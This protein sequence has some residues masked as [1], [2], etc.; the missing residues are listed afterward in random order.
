MQVF[1]ELTSI[2]GVDYLII[3]SYEDI[4]NIYA[5]LDRKASNISRRIITGIKKLQFWLKHLQ[6]RWHHEIGNSFNCSSID[7]N[8]FNNFKYHPFN[9][10]SSRIDPRPILPSSVPRK[11]IDSF[12][13]AHEESTIIKFETSSA[14]FNGDY[15]S[16]FSFIRGMSIK[17]LF[18]QCFRRTGKETKNNSNK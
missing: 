17:V 6:Q 8:Q 2:Y 13:S 7:E 5:Q 9:N 1:Q 15:S 12:L 14:S 4:C 16:S 3:L 10:L 11:F 18:Y